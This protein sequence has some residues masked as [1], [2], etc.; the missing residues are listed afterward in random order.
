MWLVPRGC[1]VSDILNALN[2]S[3]NMRL[4]SYFVGEEVGDLWWVVCRSALENI[5]T[6]LLPRLD[7]PWDAS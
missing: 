5:L 4:R 2:L 1:P 7:Y 6:E 3:S